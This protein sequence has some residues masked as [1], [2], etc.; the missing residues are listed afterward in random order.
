[1]PRRCLSRPPL[2]SGAGGVKAAGT[3]G[4]TQGRRSTFHRRADRQLQYRLR[5]AR[6]RQHACIEDIDYRHPR[7]LDKR[8]VRQLASGQYLAEHLNI[9]ITGPAGVGKTWLACA[10]A[11][12]ACRDGHSVRYLRLPRLMRC[13]STEL[14]DFSCS[15]LGWLSAS[16][17][18]LRWV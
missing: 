10:F 14:P 2:Q 12:K 18:I 5:K 6:L 13:L 8:L 7:G 16:S 11:N 9:L 15:F 3:P 1:M 17:F 4:G